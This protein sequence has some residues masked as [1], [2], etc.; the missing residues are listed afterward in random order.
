M[1][2]KFVFPLLIA[3]C[4]RSAIADEESAAL[5]KYKEPIDIAVDRALAQ[6]SKSQR[7]DGLFGG[8]YGDTTAVSA[9]A[10]MAFLAKGHSPGLGPYGDNINR[11]I[12]LVL[13]SEQKKDGQPNGYLV[14]TGHGKMYAHCI[15]TLLLSEITGMVDS[16]RQEK[17]DEVLPRAVSL[18]LEAQNVQKD[19][20]HRGGWRYEPHSRDSDLSLTGWA[21]MALRSARLNGAPVPE[22]NIERAVAYILRCQ[23]KDARGNKGFG[24]Q[25][26]QG[27]KPAMTGVAILC[28]MLTGNHDHEALPRAGDYL[29]ARDLNRRWSGEHFEYM[30]YYCTQAMFH[31]GGDYWEKWAVRFYDNALKHQ[32]KDGSWGDAYPTAMTV[33]ALTVS[34]RQLPVYQ[35]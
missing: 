29:L 4:A 34:Y 33:L 2:K 8:Q 9:L 6:L 14:R 19:E 17:I 18:I 10:A 15:S 16:Q 26:K 28:L 7:D 30:N 32:H 21:V 31:L 1:W 35:R 3:C 24:Y 23:P 25:A 13:A 11:S 27:G 5:A 22:E 12:D 20:S